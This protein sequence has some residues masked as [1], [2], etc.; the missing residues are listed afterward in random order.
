[1]ALHSYLCTTDT[2][3]TDNTE[4]LTRYNHPTFVDLPTGD[5]LPGELG[6]Y[7]GP[8]SR[9]METGGTRRHQLPGPKKHAGRQGNQS[10]MDVCNNLKDYCTSWPFNGDHPAMVYG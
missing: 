5:V 7:W 4:S 8:A 1:M 10:A 6:T 2:S 9:R 3:D